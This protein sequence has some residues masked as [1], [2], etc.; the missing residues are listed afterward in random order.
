MS[1]VSFGETVLYMPLET[2]RTNTGD[3]AKQCGV[4]IGAIERIEEVLIGTN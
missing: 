3:P 4:R 2:V 1:F